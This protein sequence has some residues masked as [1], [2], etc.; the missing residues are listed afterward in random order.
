MARSI[1]W[2]YIEEEP[3]YLLQ[4]LRNKK[5]KETIKSFIQFDSIYVCAHGSSYNAA[6]SIA[7]F[8]SRIAHVRVYV[9]TPSNFKHNAHSIH[10]E[11]KEKTLVV[12]ISET[13][14]SRGVLEELESLK[15][16][17]FQILALTN[18]KNSPID[19]LSDYSLY[20]ECENEDSNAKTKGYSCTLLLLMLIG[21]YLGFEKG[22][23]NILELETYLNEIENEVKDLENIFDSFVS[24]CKD[25]QYGN[26]MQNIYVIGDGMQFGSSLEGQLKLMETMCIPT[27]FND[28][29][30][31]SHGMHRSL[32]QNCHV[33]LLDDGTE[34]DLMEKTYRY[35]KRKEI[36]VL[37][38]TNQKYNYD[39]YIYSFKE[40][41]IDHSILTMIYLI[42]IIS[43]F[44]PELNGLD[45]NR[46]SNNEY[47]D[48]VDTRVE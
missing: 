42:Q 22:Y 39:D 6:T 30:E 12:G 4:L 19:Q 26:R 3:K 43:V 36:P 32:N 9:Y 8:I 44:V 21:L 29:G 17:R 47:T 27:M 7:G 33:L 16:E 38:L 13:G 31:F 34:K 14:T 15:K 45:P 18:T 1:M 37:L 41:K 28:I 35:L 24:W 46:D 25:A 5:N 2:Q 40:Y 20:F 23:V 10:F 11:N 48:F